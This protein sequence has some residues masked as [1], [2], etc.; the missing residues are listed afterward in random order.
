MIH[1]QNVKFYQMKQLGTIATNATDVSYLDG[2]GY[3]YAKIR[4]MV[5]PSG[6]SNASAT[7]STLALVDANDTNTTSFANVTGF[8]GGT[9]FT[10]PIVNTSTSNTI[11]E[12]NVDLRKRKRY[13]GVK[14]TP[15]VV[16]STMGSYTVFGDLSRAEVSPT[17]SAE[18]IGGVSTNLIR[19]IG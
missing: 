8:V 9:D 13:V 16:A 7:F 5:A 12:F 6:A 18:A 19:V 1:Q 2:Q 14:S 17:T 3:D 4:V 15:G 10:I 11:I